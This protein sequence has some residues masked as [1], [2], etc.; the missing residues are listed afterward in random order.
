MRKILLSM[1]LATISMNG[2]AADLFTEEFTGKVVNLS[3]CMRG[4][5]GSAMVVVRNSANTERMAFWNMGSNDATFDG[6][7]RGMYSTLLSAY[8]TGGDINIMTAPL[9]TTTEPVCVSTHD[10]VLR[11]VRLVAN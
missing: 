10:Y 5:G 4:E 7:V 3:T 8:T 6:T 11:G 9:G 2:Y 1:M